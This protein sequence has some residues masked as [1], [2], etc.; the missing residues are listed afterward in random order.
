[1][2]L[3]EMEIAS[4]EPSPTS[5][6]ETRVFMQMSETLAVS[7]IKQCRKR[8]HKSGSLYSMGCT[9]TDKILGIKV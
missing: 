6:M 1:M 5:S 9:N 7:Y 4:L 2:M 8:Y 3:K